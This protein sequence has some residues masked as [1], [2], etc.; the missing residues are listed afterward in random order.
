MQDFIC[1]FWIM[2]PHLEDTKDEGLELRPHLQGDRR[3]E[4]R[5]TL[6]WEDGRDHM[7]RQ[8]EGDH[9]E[10]M[11]VYCYLRD[12]RGL[13]EQVGTAGQ[14]L[15]AHISKQGMR[16][17]VK[18]NDFVAICP[19]RALKSPSIF[20]TFTSFTNLSNHPPWGLEVTTP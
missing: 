14:H 19:N 20:C 3:D 4:R 12:P 17:V 16:Q 7:G 9:V 8:G 10:E 6:A 1:S 15:F 5:D 13:S 11:R 18:C 2:P